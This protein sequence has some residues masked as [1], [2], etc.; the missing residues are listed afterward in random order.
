MKQNQFILRVGAW[1]AAL[2]TLCLIIQFAIGLSIGA[3]IAD[4]SSYAPNVVV[5]LIQAQSEKIKW[6]FMFDDIFPVLYFAAF[7]GLYELLRERGGI[8]ARIALIFGALTA[9]ADFFENSNVLGLVGAVGVAQTIA[10]EKMFAL[11]II[12]Q[13]KFLFT[14]VTVFLFGA[15]LWNESRLRRAAS[16]VALIFVPV[17]TLAF[18]VS[19]FSLVRIFGMLAL[20]V[21]TALVLG[22]SEE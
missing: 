19:G 4:L 17:N 3:A 13:M 14:S 22:K 8:L 10:P 20:L 18:I 5:N 16:I 7:I 15:C 21:L 9:V 2:A 1:S 12:A 11:N 6:L